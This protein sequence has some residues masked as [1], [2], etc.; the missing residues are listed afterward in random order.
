MFYLR[1]M[2]AELRRRRGRT[3]LTSLGLAVGVGLVATVVALSRGLDDAQSEVLEPLTGVGTDMSVTRPILISGN[4]SDREVTLGPGGAALTGKERRQLLDENGDVHAMLPQ[5]GEAPPGT[6][7]SQQFFIGTDLS[8]PEREVR[9]VSRL[10]GVEQAAPALRLNLVTL[11]GQVPEAGA[12]AG[13][14]AQTG[15][16]V[17]QQSVTGVDVS[18]AN[19]A[20]VTPSQIASGRYFRSG[21]DNASEAVLGESY[22]SRQ[23]LAVGD[24]VTVDK[25]SFTVVG[26]AKP[27][28]GGQASDIYLPLE[29]LQALSDRRGRVN[30]LRVRAASTDQVSDVALRIEQTF[31]GS[32]VTT[33]RDL[34]DRVSGSLTDAQDL[35]GSLGTALA[36]VAL[37]AAVG[38]ASL[39]TLS[40]V[41]RRTREL[42]TLKAIGWRRWLVVRQITG[43]SLAQ[44]ALGGGVGALLGV[45]GAA[46]ISA[47]GPTLEASVSKAPPSSAGLI[48]SFAQGQVATGSSS[49]ALDAP[50]DISMLVVAIGLALAGGL[51]AG[52][53]GAARAARLSPAEALRSVE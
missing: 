32:Q 5:A 46:L 26:I 29:V 11:S 52:A 27:P 14:P 39:L 13:A 3:V 17:S 47:I 35:S 19:L 51:V 1:Y 48:G 8:F 36:I 22:A 6:P 28:L 33:A 9:R 18:T 23:Q 12:A 53:T 41:N 30:D 45:G 21:G 24:R 31:A 42:G 15:M 34:A 10:D 25:R 2:A 7:F 20:P 40:S 37:V 50:I 4:G 38:L 44:G 49:V 16:G 43:E